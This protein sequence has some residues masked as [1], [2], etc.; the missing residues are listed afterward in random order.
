MSL[1]LQVLAQG[2]KVDESNVTEFLHDIEN[3]LNEFEQVLATGFG[4]NSFLSTFVSFTRSY[5]I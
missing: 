3:K 4:R 5:T 2:I 1:I